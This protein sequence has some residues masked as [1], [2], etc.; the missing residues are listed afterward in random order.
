MDLGFKAQK[1]TNHKL[2]FPSSS[3]LAHKPQ[4]LMSTTQVNLL[5]VSR[6]CFI[7]LTFGI[8][9]EDTTTHFASHGQ[10]ISLGTRLN[11]SFASV[12]MG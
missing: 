1:P 9:E 11:F 4:T 12:Y 5:N 10:I 3:S 7:P 6:H 2:S 8:I